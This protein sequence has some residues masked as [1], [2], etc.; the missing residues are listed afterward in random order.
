M[1]A[2]QLMSRNKATVKEELRQLLL[3]DCD[4]DIQAAFGPHFYTTEPL[5]LQLVREI[6]GLREHY[7]RASENTVRSPGDAAG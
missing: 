3:A 1:D 4:E 2:V 5:L 7:L 6:R